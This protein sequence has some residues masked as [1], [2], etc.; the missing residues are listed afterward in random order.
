MVIK[1]QENACKVFNKF[2]QRLAPD[3]VFPRSTSRQRLRV[4]ASQGA[5]ILALCR[6]LLSTAIDVKL[7]SET[8]E[9]VTAFFFVL[10][11]Q[12]LQSAFFPP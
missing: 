4:Y 7:P 1:N 8:I 9:N 3:L 11:S 6:P 12:I 10:Q 5:G 2:C